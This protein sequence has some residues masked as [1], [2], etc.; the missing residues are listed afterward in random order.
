M[1]A[2]PAYR[3]RGNQ[4]PKHS[5]F[6]RA[7]IAIKDA[8]GVGIGYE[9]E[10]STLRWH[11]LHEGSSASATF[12]QNINGTER[13]GSAFESG[14]LFAENE[15]PLF[16]IWDESWQGF[17]GS[18]EHFDGIRPKTNVKVCRHDVK[19][20]IPLDERSNVIGKD[21]VAFSRERCRR[22]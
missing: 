2:N 20:A 13:E 10:K 14:F 5:E 3:N 6:P 7:Q 18:V 19:G 12:A 1:S 9:R 4:L 21:S 22:G 15:T 17:R 11:W 8:I 16:P